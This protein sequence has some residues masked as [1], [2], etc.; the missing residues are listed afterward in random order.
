MSKP[1]CQVC[2]GT[3]NGVQFPMFPKTEGFKFGEICVPCDE[4]GK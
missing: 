3:G 1:V 2:K 4:K